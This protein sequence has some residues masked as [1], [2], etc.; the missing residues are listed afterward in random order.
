MIEIASIFSSLVSFIFN[1]KETRPF[2]GAIPDKQR[3]AVDDDE[4][5]E[6]LL[7]PCRVKFTHAATESKDDWD[8]FADFQD[9]IEDNFRLVPMAQRSNTSLGTLD[10]S[11]EEESDGEFF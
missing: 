8:H 2:D 3:Q 11:E 6:L 10:E 5:D 9:E 1:E 7:S 4:P